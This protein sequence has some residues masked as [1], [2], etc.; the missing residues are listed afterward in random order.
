MKIS[1][2]DRSPGLTYEVEGWRERL[3]EAMLYVSWKCQDDPR[4]GLVKLFKILYFADF[5]AFLHYGSP[6]TGAPY[7]RLRHGPIPVHGYEVKEELMGT[8]DITVEKQEY[9]DL[10]Q[11]RVVP[12]HPP[13]YSLL[14]PRDVEVLDRW[15]DKL[16]LLTASEVSTLSHSRAWEV[17]GDKEQIPY[18]AAFLSDDS[19]TAAEAEHL[20]ELAQRHGWDA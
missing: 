16:R 7:Y 6:V 2:P 4:F 18:E 5:D 13:E 14:G 8:G 20:R 11:Q 19:L 1:G 3:K 9:F 17:A 12:T 10:Q 15:I